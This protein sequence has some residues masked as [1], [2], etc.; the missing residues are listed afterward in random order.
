MKITTLEEDRYEKN[1]AM[2][3]VAGLTVTAAACS[4]DTTA[5]VTPPTQLLSVVPQGGATNVDPTLPVTV[6]FDHPLAQQMTEYAS[7]H[8][9]DVTG[10][11]VPGT[12][13]FEQDDSV[14]VFTPDQPLKPATQY[15]IHLGG[16]MMDAQG[17]GWQGSN[18]MYGMVFTFTKRRRFVT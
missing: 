5:P 9:G 7:L 17:D 16:G 13:A 11:V 2:A 10:P 15:T 6:T 1:V 14:L 8:E 12:W 3:F 4:K 18:G